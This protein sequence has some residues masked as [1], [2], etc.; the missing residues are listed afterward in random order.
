MDK[1]ECTHCFYRSSYKY[2]LKRHIISRHG[3][4][5]NYQCEQCQKYFH[6]QS[7][8]DR[9]RPVH[10]VVPKLL[11]PCQQC[12]KSF[13]HLKRL[14]QHV[15]EVHEERGTRFQ[16]SECT[17]AFYKFVSLKR[18]FFSVHRT[19]RPF[20]CLFCSRDYKLKY[21]LDAHVRSVHVK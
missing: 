10:N 3:E 16:C 13:L 1:Y 8:L 5:S 20:K 19:E 6:I 7:R 15:Q 2:D 18:H 12:D 9:H 17:M 11:Y 4:A 21:N 14:K